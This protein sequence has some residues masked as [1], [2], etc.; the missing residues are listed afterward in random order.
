MK[1]NAGRVNTHPSAV[2]RRQLAS[3]LKSG[4]HLHEES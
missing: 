4:S 1:R 2:C 3:A